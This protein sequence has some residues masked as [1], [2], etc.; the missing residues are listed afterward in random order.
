MK[1]LLFL[2]IV[3]SF[4]LT[5][6]T[7][8]KQ[9]FTIKGKI[10][11][12]RKYSKAWVAL[13]TADGRADTLAQAEFKDSTFVLQGEVDKLTGAFL[14]FRALYDYAGPSIVLQTKV[15]V[16]MVLEGGEYEVVMGGSEE[17][18]SSVSGGGEEQRVGSVFEDTRQKDGIR[19]TALSSIEREIPADD[20][21][22]KLIAQLDLEQCRRNLL[23][24]LQRLVAASKETY[25]AALYAE[26]MTD[27]R[28]LEEQRET[29]NLLGDQAKAT[30]PAKRL[31]AVIKQKESIA[32]GQ[33]A[34]DFTLETPEGKSITLHAV[35]GKVKLIDFWASWCGPCRQENPA[36]KK[37]YEEYHAK[38]LEIVGV[39]CD[40]DREK[41]LKAIEEDAL[42]WAHGWKTQALKLYGVKAIPFTVLLDKKNRIIA[43]D[44]RGK[45]LYD[46]IAEL[47]D[48]K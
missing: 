45:A 22:M 34:P 13:L 16:Y 35:R 23:E 43:T 11:G 41:W 44:L 4:L 8:E 48:K 2:S 28:S 27:N 40:T 36:V 19:R 37:M 29:Y 46:K 18:G 25:A 39:S 15:N 24:K 42:P 20:A 7:P 17:G 5:G 6:F 30:E 32:I 9:Q 33:V 21:Q 3:A 10:V 26:V 12:A 14:K 31:L 1:N 38:G 47:L